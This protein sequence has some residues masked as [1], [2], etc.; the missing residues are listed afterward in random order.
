[1]DEN[2]IV[3]I[4]LAGFVVVGTGLIFLGNT[5]GPSTT[6]GTVAGLFGF[7]FVGFIP[8]YFWRKDKG[9]LFG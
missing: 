7:V 3:K 5:L 9:T 1:M 6:L 2:K 4:T 8:F